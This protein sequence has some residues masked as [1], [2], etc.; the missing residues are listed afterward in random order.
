MAI[1]ICILSSLF[2]GFFDLTRK[3]SLIFF[4]AKTILIFFSLTQVIVF[5]TWIHFDIFKID[6]EKYFI[7]GIIL[8]VISIL[9]SVL[10]LESLKLSDLSLTIPLLSFT[11]LFSSIF[12]SIILNEDLVIE[13]YIG[14]FFIIFGTLILYSR[15]LNFYNI[16]FSVKI[17]VYDRGAS[18]MLLVSLIWSLTPILDKVCFNYSSIPTHGL[19][20]SF[21]ML[22]VLVFLSPK[23]KTL[24]KILKKNF[25]ILF[26]TIMVGV[27]ATVLQFFAIK[28]TIVP[29]METIKRT[30]GQFLSIIFG[31]I[32]F[33]EKFSIQ[34]FI[35]I[36]LMTIG[37]ANILLF[38]F[39]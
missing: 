37:I 3:K 33:K 29:I 21:G 18:Y 13:Q 35:G 38:Q 26:L 9:S 30:M 8:I 23:N 11:P 14:I 32:F 5:S 31:K 39:F 2:W 27:I 4:D 28:L 25:L 15:K 19:I 36:I 22:I 17:I 20:Q 7:P 16:F 12:S 24:T 34:K 6:L 1:L 10:F